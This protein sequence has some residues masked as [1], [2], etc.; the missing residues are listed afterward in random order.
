MALAAHPVLLHNG[1]PVH[2]FAWTLH[3]PAVHALAHTP[4]YSDAMQTTAAPGRTAPRL[5]LPNLHPGA[6]RPHAV[7]VSDLG[8]V[9]L[10]DSSRTYTTALGTRE[11]RAPELAARDIERDFPAPQQRTPS[12]SSPL[13]P[14]RLTP[15][16]DVY[17]LGCIAHEL[18]RPG[19]QM[20]GA[21]SKH[22]MLRRI[23]AGT[24]HAGAPV[25]ERAADICPIVADA[26]RW[27]AAPLPEDRPSA[28]EFR[29]RVCS[30][31]ADLIIAR[32]SRRAAPLLSLHREASSGE[33]ER[34]P[35][36]LVARSELAV[37]ARS[38]L[39]RRAGDTADAVVVA[40]A[41]ARPGS[42]L[43]H[44][45]AGVLEVGQAVP[46]PGKF[47]GGFWPGL[48]SRIEEKIA[49][50][51]AEASPTAPGM[52]SLQCAD[53]R[54]SADEPSSS[55]AVHAEP[56]GR[57]LCL[58]DSGRSGVGWTG[59]GVA[60]AGGATDSAANAMGL[61]SRG[62]SVSGAQFSSSFDALVAD[63]TAERSAQAVHAPRAANVRGATAPDAR[64]CAVDDGGDHCGW[65]VHDEVHAHDAVC[66]GASPSE[67][68]TH[69][70]APPAAAALAAPSPE[71]PASEDWSGWVCAGRARA[72]GAACA[73]TTA[74]SFGL[75]DPSNIG[76]VCL[77]E[78]SAGATTPEPDRGLLHKKASRS[79]SS[80]VRRSHAR[81]HGIRRRRPRS[82]SSTYLR[83]PFR[84]ISQEHRN[85]SSSLDTR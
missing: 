49:H 56:D 20:T 80:E 9:R 15:A 82:P 18:I 46:S 37:L 11:T 13:P 61:P 70:L 22:E 23:A 67:T 17:S 50:L 32:H 19:A 8:K 27:A 14:L 33:G 59:F 6:C 12:G 58:P 2:R 83:L 10:P 64:P 53:A 4:Q 71:P 16:Q 57:M 51:R 1:V 42:V 74:G 3:A 25:G 35:G 79:L 40:A 81:G 72:P 24:A 85:L 68:S 62:A 48:N 60:S 65:R 75:S 54:S 41:A 30:V 31:V 66:H 47:E 43:V 45:R 5:G 34:V 84:L 78:S 26:A 38:T 7:V 69:F 63:G 21:L 55:C 52:A 44:E 39:T 28:L 29:R 73:S 76:S 36:W 77:T